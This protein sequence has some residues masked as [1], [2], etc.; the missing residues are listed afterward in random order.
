VCDVKVVRRAWGVSR[1]GSP[2]AF[3]GGETVCEFATSYA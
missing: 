3:R 1:L 2:G